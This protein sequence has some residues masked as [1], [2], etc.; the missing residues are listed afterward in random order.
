MMGDDTNR[1]Q[2]VSVGARSRCTVAVKQFL[3][4]A[5]A[6]L[7]DFSCKVES[8]SGGSIVVERLMYSRYGT[9]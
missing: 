6:P 9:R 2:A 8:N 7:H 5:D 3:G 1:E 4:E